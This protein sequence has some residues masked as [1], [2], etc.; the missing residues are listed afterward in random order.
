MYSTNLDNPAEGLTEPAFVATFA[1]FLVAMALLCVAYC[2]ASLRT[3][4]VFFL[5]FLT[6]IPTCESSPRSSSIDPP[7]L[8]Q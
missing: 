4:V 7:D 3:N 2:I 6:L 1:F 5:I 8:Q